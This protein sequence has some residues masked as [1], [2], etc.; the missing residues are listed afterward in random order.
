MISLG[1]LQILKM[2]KMLIKQTGGIHGLID[3]NNLDKAINISFS[4][5][6][7]NQI[8]NSDIEK[9]AKLSFNIIKFKPFIE[10]NT[11]TGI[12]CLLVLLEINNINI[13]YTTKELTELGKNLT[14]SFMDYKNFVDWI[15]SHIKM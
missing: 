5:I 9:I 3:I 12:L 11:N 13:K 2:H 10:G 7:K 6:I 14:Y 8:N 1:K 15:N 4:D